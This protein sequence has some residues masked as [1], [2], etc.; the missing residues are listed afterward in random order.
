[1]AAVGALSFDAVGTLFVPHPSV[2]AIYAEIAQRHGF[3]C[4]AAELEAAF[5]AAFAAV[6]ARWAVPYGADDHDALSFWAQ[7][8]EGTFGAPL[9]FEAV[10]DLYDTFASGARWRVV[11]G[12][13]EALALGRERGLPLAVVS[14]Y[15]SRLQPVLDDLGLGPFAAVVPSTAVGKAKPDPA[16][17]LEACRRMGVSPDRVLHLGDSEREDG[18]LCAAT[19]ARW[20]RVDPREGISLPALRAMLD[21]P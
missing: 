10:C 8:I 4:D 20:L 1:V 6:R 21:A 17:L 2:G 12:A 19:G 9:S 16:P 7:V 15:D 13:R 18:G 3:D 14:N 11:A 5:P